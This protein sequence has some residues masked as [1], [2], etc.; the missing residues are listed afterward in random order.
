MRCCQC[1]K[2]LPAGALFCKYC[3]TK[4]TPSPEPKAREAAAGQEVPPVCASPASGPSPAGLAEDSHPSGPLLAPETI[5]EFNS[6]R[7]E[8]PDVPDCP[9]GE[10]GASPVGGGNP[11]ISLPPDPEP[12]APPHDVPEAADEPAAP[13][14]AP[15]I[16]FP[17]P[18]HPLEKTPLP[19]DT[20]APPT[21]VPDE[22]A[23]P[24]GDSSLPSQVF[25]PE[26]LAPPLTEPPAPQATPRQEELVFDLDQILPQLS[27]PVPGSQESPPEQA[28][29]GQSKPL[30]W[31]DPEQ[32]PSSPETSHVPARQSCPG[33]TAPE[34]ASPAEKAVE[35]KVPAEKSPAESFRRE[36][37][38]VEAPAEDH[39]ETEIPSEEP[40]G[41]GVPAGNP[42]SSVRQHGST[43]AILWRLAVLAVELGVIVFL[44]LRLF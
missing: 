38:S 21:A 36:A 43:G 1:Q 42:P 37:A 12:V 7:E 19:E 35:E 22:E 8:G 10:P 33:E 28:A 24:A 44:I 18:A 29:S 16:T 34:A 31:F 14:P 17:P 23:P 26:E 20:A 30:A 6:R 25:S 32:L 9:D 41:R 40:A 2:E 39:A 4:Q 27:V 3:G 13:P 5:P 11:S 15:E